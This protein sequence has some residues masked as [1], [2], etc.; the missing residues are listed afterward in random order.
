MNCLLDTHAFLWWD[1]ERSRLSSRVLVISATPNTTLFLSYASI[2]ELQIK[3]QLG[4]LTARRPLSQII[5]EQ[6][7]LNGLRLLPILPDHIYALQSL[8]NLH[9][10]PFDRMLIAQAMHENMTLISSDSQI[11]QY[12]IPILW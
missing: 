7:T 10:D 1:G 5:Q 8:P 4:K 3:L 9:G 11:A 2:W 6:T 12:P